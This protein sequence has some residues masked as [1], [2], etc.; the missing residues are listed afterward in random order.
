MYMPVKRSVYYRT[1]AISLPA[2]YPSEMENLHSHRNLHANVY[3]SFVRNHET[4]QTTHMSF[5]KR[6]DRQNVVRPYNDM[7][8]PARAAPRKDACKLAF[9]GFAIETKFTESKIWPL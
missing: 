5:N 1:R 2:L 9:A 4:L 7:N 8:Y 3:D 6:T